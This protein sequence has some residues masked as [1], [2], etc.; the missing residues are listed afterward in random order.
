MDN[1]PAGPIGE[2]GSPARIRDG[3]FLGPPR[4]YWHRYGTENP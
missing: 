1:P 2:P 3:T 4:P